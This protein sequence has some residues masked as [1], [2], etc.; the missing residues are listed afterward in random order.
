MHSDLQQK[1][2]LSPKKFWKKLLPSFFGF[3]FMPIFFGGMGAAF[4]ASSTIGNSDNSEFIG[5]IIIGAVLGFIIHLI[6]TIFR[7]WYLKVY[8]RT[9]YYAGEEHFITIKKGVFA[10]TEIHVQWQKIQDVYVDQDILDRIMGLYD[11]HIA[12]ATAASGIEAHIDGIEK[13][14]A[15]GLKK[16]LL[17]KVS[18]SGNSRNSGNN[19]RLQNSD[20][21]SAGHDSHINQADHANSGA[22]SQSKKSEITFATKDGKNI[23][24]K[25]YPLT[26]KWFWV[27]ITQSVIGSFIL[28][29]LL[30]LVFI[31]KARSGDYF[32]EDMPQ[33]ILIWL[34]L[35]II[36]IAW[37]VISL[38]LWKKNYVFDFTPENIYFKQGVLS[39]S[40]N[41]MPYSSI[42]DVTVR[43]SF[44][45][46][47]FG[48]GRVVIENASQQSVVVGR[49]GNKEALFNGIILQGFSISDAREITNTLKSTVLGKGG[50]KY[51]V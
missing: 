15:D 35:A 10:P 1:Y 50:S 22:T 40:E 26:S 32:T 7:A 20:A 37:R 17:E 12:S 16:F 4:G 49:G 25:N 45:E 48:L 21:G 34:G 41:H 9:Y 8:I 29:G 13:E 51:G 27:S 31:G 14:A 36:I 44:I 2:P 6:I 5:F 18:G 38:F 24:S 39:I 19:N 47:L 28:A 46:R 43:Q 3:I 23:S 42:Q 30:V 33:M 11:V